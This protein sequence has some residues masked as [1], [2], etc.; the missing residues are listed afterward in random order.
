MDL[1]TAYRLG[2]WIQYARLSVTALHRVIGERRVLWGLKLVKSDLENNN[3]GENALKDIS[4]WIKKLEKEYTD[5]SVKLKM[6]DARSLRDD[7]NQ[8]VDEVEADLRKIPI[9][10][11]QLK[12]GLNPDELMKLAKKEPSEFISDEEWKQL[13]EIE[14]SDFSDSARC[15]LLGTA[16]PSVMVALRG[17]EASIRNF[18]Q[19]KTKQPPGKKTWRLLT[20]ELKDQAQTLGIEDTFIGFLDSFGDAKRNFAQHPNKVYT[21]REAVMI[22]MQV[23]ALVSDIY[24]QI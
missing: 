24:T 13:T 20:K 16:T 15:L 6:E 22:F 2:L 21:L 19:C 1:D 5:E 18:Y 23:V 12:S 10:E 17:A 3:I 4:K 8:W 7:A 9:V 11:M 14:K